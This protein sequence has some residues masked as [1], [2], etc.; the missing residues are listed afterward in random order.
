VNFESTRSRLP[1]RSVRRLRALA[2]PGGLIILAGVLFAPERIWPSLL[3]VTYFLVSTALAGAFFVALQYV[4]G[5]GWSVALRRVPET[6]A[7]L[8]P[9]AGTAFILVLLVRPSLYPWAIHEGGHEALQ[10]FKAFWLNRP[11]F[12]ARAA[13]YLALWIGLVLAIVRSSRRQDSD[14]ALEHTARNE[15]LSA[16]FIVVFA[17]TFSLAAFD[18]IM[19]REPHWSSTIFGIYNFAGMFLGGLAAMSVLAVW[20]ERLGPLHGVLNESHLHDLGRLLFAF[21]TFWAYIWFSQ[22]MLVWYADFP[23]ET[24]YYTRRLHGAWEP[25]FLLNFLLNWVVPFLALLSRTAKRSAGV[26]LKVGLVVLIGRWLDLYLMIVPPQ[27]PERLPLGLWEVGPLVAAVGLGLLAFFHYLRQ[28]S[29]VP[30]RDP[31]LAESLGHGRD[32][33]PSGISGGSFR[34]SSDTSEVQANVIE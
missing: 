16:V 5:A 33:M 23:E 29:V 17:L 14:G 11:F 22:Y 2:A 10:G 27:A 25:L 19:S 26:L 4:A 31:F 9:A 3:L 32:L 18:W 30:L 20:L 21:S 1:E 8:L 34:A 15:K 12:L 7:M 13:V 24:V 28:A 6:L